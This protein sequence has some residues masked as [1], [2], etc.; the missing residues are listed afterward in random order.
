MPARPLPYAEE[1]G[2]VIFACYCPAGALPYICMRDNDVCAVILAGGRSSR[3]G[4][5]KALIDIAGHPLIEIIIDRVRPVA[6]QILISSGDSIKYREFGFPVVTDLFK[7][8]GPLAGLHA[9]MLYK[10]RFRYLA[11]ACDLPN[12]RTD[13]LRTLADLSDGNDAVI[14]RTRDGLAHPLCAVYRESCFPFI[15]QA[16]TRGDA[17]VIEILLSSP[18]S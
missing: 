7:N 15:D 13:F 8:H 1:P 9:A 14:P 10:P 12:L 18:L 6:G 4:R 16:L 11:L 17:K 3:M 2:E 5:D